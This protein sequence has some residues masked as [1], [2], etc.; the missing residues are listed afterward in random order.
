[1]RRRCL[2][3]AHRVKCASHGDVVDVV[4]GLRGERTGLTPTGHTRINQTLIALLALLRTQSDPL[5]DAG[6]Q[7][8][9]Q[10]VRPLDDLER[11]GARI[12]ALEIQSDREPATIEDVES[13]GAGLDRRAA[14]T[15]DPDDVRTE[16]GEDHRGERRGPEAGDF[17]DA[18]AGKRRGLTHV[19]LIYQ[20]LKNKYH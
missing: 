5:H 11:Q 2:R 13:F 8:L 19:H 7:S 20:G 14:R 10:N 1:W 9:Q 3:R 15:I 17:D 6:T 16:V 18:Q 4:S 12:V